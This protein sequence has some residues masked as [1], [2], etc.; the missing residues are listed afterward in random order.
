MPHANAERT[1]AYQLISFIFIAMLLVFVASVLVTR[2]VYKNIILDSQLDKMKHLAHE[3]IYLIDGILHKVESLANT[4]VN[5]LQDTEISS[6]SLEKHFR[7]VIL[8]NRDVNSVSLVSL[9]PGNEQAL[10]FY[11][12]Q[13]LVVRKE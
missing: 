11:P 1:L 7:N 13:H 9:I 3:R 8:D 2:V 12:H 10:L 4:S 5:L 6:S